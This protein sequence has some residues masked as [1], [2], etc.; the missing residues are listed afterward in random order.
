MR[1]KQVWALH[2]NKIKTYSACE[3]IKKSFPS[4]HLGRLVGFPHR[5]MQNLLGPFDPLS[6]EKPS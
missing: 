3:T 2:K 6:A 4:T 1:L 5:S